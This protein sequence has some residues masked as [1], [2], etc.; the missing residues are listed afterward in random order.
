MTRRFR[1]VRLDRLN[2]AHGAYRSSQAAA[3][4]G[5]SA[6][7]HAGDVF[8]AIERW[9]G[10]GVCIALRLIV[11]YTARRHMGGRSLTSAHFPAG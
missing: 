3:P 11:Q 1:D 8:E 6:A 7:G 4:M 2:A 10:Y 9:G 5:F